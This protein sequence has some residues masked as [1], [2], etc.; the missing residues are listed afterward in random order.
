MSGIQ[1]TTWLRDLGYTLRM[2]TKLSSRMVLTT[3]TT[4]SSQKEAKTEHSDFLTQT[5]KSQ[6]SLL[7]VN[8]AET[9]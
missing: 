5:A 6:V 2:T 9:Q 4:S 8:S 3:Q 1:Q 7:T